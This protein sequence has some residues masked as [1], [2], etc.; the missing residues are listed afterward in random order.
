MDSEKRY[1]RE[2]ERKPQATEEQLTEWFKEINKY[3][4][5]IVEGNLKL[6]SKYA[7]QMAKAWQTIDVMD[8]IQEGNIGL[9][10]AVD[11]FKPAKGFKFSTIATAY[12]QGYMLHYIR[13]NV[14]FFKISNKDQRDVFDNINK[15]RYKFNDE[16]DP[17][18]WLDEIQPRV[19]TLEAVQ[20][21]AIQESPEDLYLRSEARA[22][23]Y[24]KITQFEATLSKVH[25]QVWKYRIL[26]QEKTLQECVKEGIGKYPEDVRRKEN[27]V[28]E[29]ARNY[30]SQLDFIDIIG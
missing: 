20:D 2:L 16:E 15:M 10:K 14:G 6:V 7:Y 13:D 25:R 1:M 21:D 4:N 29:K 26:S 8:L 24:K 3:R 28:I 12:I 22:N 18:S 5:K 17:L 27:K 30:F 19:Q 9:I 11:A 23:L